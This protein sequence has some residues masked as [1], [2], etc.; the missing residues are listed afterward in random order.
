MP[1]PGVVAV[2]GEALV[3]IV[4]AP[5][6]GYHELAPGGSPANTAVGL[7]RL[8]VPVRML[9]RLAD[10]LLGRRLRAHLERNGVDLRHVVAAAE[11]SSMAV[12]EVDERGVASYDFRVDGTADW[13]WT[14]AEL[15][16]ALSVDQRGGPVVALHTGSLALTT[17]PGAAVLRD[18]V[19]RAAPTAT[20]SY[21]PN[22]RPLLMG[23]VGVVL[24][25][26]HEMVGLA[27]VV[28][29]SSE[30]LD[31][32][33]P[34]TS[35]EA[36]VDDWLARGAALVAVTLGAD[37]VL[38]GTAAGLWARLP[39][40]PV[41]VVDTVGAGDTFSAGLL[42]GLHMRGLLGAAAREALRAIASDDLDAVLDG[43]IRAA[44]ITCSRRGADPPT[45]EELARSGAPDRP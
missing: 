21:D 22:C 30:D 45:A 9:A 38:A 44:A 2:A 36:V 24:A 27:D 14:A 23:D 13:Q 31:W 17:A 41:Q 3:D 16:D 11:P 37:G 18:L 25:G 32:L 29:V 6:A 4:P 26:V 19:R 1:A 42:A 20:V 7:A 8:G 34:G 35:Y 39:G 40:R 5:V 33:L 43:A 10:D 12:V 15:A 28:K